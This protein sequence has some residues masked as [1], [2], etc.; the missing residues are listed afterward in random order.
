MPHK[1]S[2]SEEKSHVSPAKSA[3]KSHVSPAKSIEKSR[4]SP[5][6]SVEKSQYKSCYVGKKSHM[7][8]VKSEEVICESGEVKRKVI[9]AFCSLRR[10]VTYV[11][12]SQ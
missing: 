7:S 8:P 11:Q 3:E 9:H 5:A 1:Q 12:L 10:E 2:N 4:V 6:K